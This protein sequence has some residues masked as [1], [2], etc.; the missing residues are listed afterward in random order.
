MNPKKTIAI[1][2]IILILLDLDIYFFITFLIV[3]NQSITILEYFGKSQTPRNRNDVE[4][5][6][7]AAGLLVD[8]GAVFTVHL[9]V[10]EAVPSPFVGIKYGKGVNKPSSGITA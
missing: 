4:K 9:E 2:Q 3:P 8:N 1:A 6:S 10:F 5:F 7:L